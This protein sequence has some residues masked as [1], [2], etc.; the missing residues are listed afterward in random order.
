MV[1]NIFG[2]ANDAKKQDEV[3]DKVNIHS[4]AILN[5]VE[6]QKNLEATG[7]LIS[8]KIEMLDH[9]SMKE[10]KEIHSDMKNMRD[11]IRDLKQ[12]IA[13]IKDFNSKTNKQ[14]K[15][16]SPKDDVMKLEKYIDLWNPMDFVS[17]DELELFREKIKE[18]LINIV[19]G[20]LKK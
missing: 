10:F 2:G 7:D 9:N 13:L 14:F 17:R 16:M 20:F 4:K 3:N 5:L 12:E 6:R 18:D 8:E 15:L 11:D 1:G 19:E